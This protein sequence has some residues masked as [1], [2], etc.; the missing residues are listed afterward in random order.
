MSRITLS[1]RSRGP[2]LGA[3]AGASAMAV[4]R[5]PALAI[6]LLAAACQTGPRQPESPQQARERAIRAHCE[7][8]AQSESMRQYRL[9][10]SGS[11]AVS[12]AAQAFSAKA[13]VDAARGECLLRNGLTP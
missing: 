10:Q 4:S 9:M 11:L 5:Y 1:P 13:A 12:G 3:F 2:I 8:V 7:N 6:M